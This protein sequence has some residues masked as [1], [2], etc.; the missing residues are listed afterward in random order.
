MFA[1]TLAERIETIIF[2]T[3]TGK[4]VFSGK[5]GSVEKLSRGYKVTTSEGVTVVAFTTIA[6]WQVN[7]KTFVGKAT[8]LLEAAHAALTAE[9]CGKGRYAYTI[10]EGCFDA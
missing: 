4:P 5:F 3:M 7:Y 10:N 6:G 1:T 9:A 8:S 2:S